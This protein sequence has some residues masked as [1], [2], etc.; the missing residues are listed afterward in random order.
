[1]IPEYV[2]YYTNDFGRTLRPEAHLAY[3]SVL[4]ALLRRFKFLAFCYNILTT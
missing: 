4:E 3:I 1:M 2:E